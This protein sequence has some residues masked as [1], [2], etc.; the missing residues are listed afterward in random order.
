MS[1]YP[2][3][4]EQ[5][6][7]RPVPDGAFARYSARPVRTLDDFQKV[8]AIRA[9]VFMAE[10]DCPYE[11]EFDGNDF[12]A[13]HFVVFDG[14]SPVGTL[15]LRWF[16]GFAKL[17]RVVLLRGQRGRPALQVM[18]AEAFELATRKGYRR[19]IAQIQARLWP[20]WSR[21]FRCRLTADR[22]RFWFSDFEYAEIEIDLPEH[23]RA[24]APDS[25]PMVM[26]RPEGEWDAPGVLDASVA[27]TDRPDVAA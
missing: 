11:E 1:A 20:V 4:G 14:D 19:M 12:C 18:L 2:E 23:P 9:A 27:R 7:C 21:T 17:E 6:L 25:D 8:V 16:A 26:I 15:R 24:L 22:P 10:Q 5:A 3:I 13:T